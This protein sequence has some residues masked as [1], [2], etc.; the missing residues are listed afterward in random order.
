M[1]NPQMFVEVVASGA[2]AAVTVVGHGD[3]VGDAFGDDEDFVI[4]LNSSA[5]SANAV[6]TDVLVG[7]PV[8][9]ALAANSA[10]LSNTTEDGDILFAVA[11]GSGNSQGLLMLDGSTG[12]IGIGGIGGAVDTILHIESA[13]PN[14]KIQDSSG[15]G[16]GAVAVVSFYDNVP[17][18]MGFIGM[19][20]TGNSDIYLHANAG[21]LRLQSEASSAVLIEG[22]TPTLTIGDSGTEDA[23]IIFD[24][25]AFDAYI[26]TGYDETALIIG[27]GQTVGTNERIAPL[28]NT[29]AGGATT[30]AATFRIGGA[31]TGATP[32]AGNFAMWVQ[33]GTSKF[34]GPI[35]INDSANTDMT[36]GL[37]INQGAADDHIFALKSSDINHGITTVAETDTYGFAKKQSAAGGLNLVGLA[38]TGTR[39]LAIE[40]IAISADTNKT[41]ASGDAAII[42]KGWMKDGTGTQVLGADGN[43][44][45]IHDGATGVRFIFDVEGSG[46]ADVEWTTFDTYD[47]L[48]LI[49]DIEKELVASESTRGTEHRHMLEN[50]GIIGKDSWH[51][52]NGRPRAMVNM[53]KLSMLHHGALMQAADKIKALENRLLAIEGAK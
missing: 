36:T 11:D 49:N 48:S 53:T 38:H 42:L 28:A 51:V 46:H 4:V 8:T 27:Q 13:D 25:N 26:A 6:V 19:G 41:Y 45:A 52:E 9:P 15:S 47:D 31:P 35:F 33:G 44:L 23:T 5:Y 32:T 10:I 1:P 2:Q 43:I 37:T 34:D 7:T 20:S 24:G 18:E 12:R 17:T 29:N 39:A 3:N 22:T 21:N 30:N 40:G 14:L 16:D 50:T